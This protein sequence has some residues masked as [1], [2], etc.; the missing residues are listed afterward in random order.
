VDATAHQCCYGFTIYRLIGKVL[1]RL[2][3]SML[4]L[5]KAPTPNLLLST[6]ASLLNIRRFAEAAA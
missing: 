2:A 3:S 1:S 6:T 4:S 5:S